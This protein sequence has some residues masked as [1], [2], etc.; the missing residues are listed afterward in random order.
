MTSLLRQSAIALLAS[1]VAVCVSVAQAATPYRVI[2]YATEWNAQQAGTLEHIDALIFAF[3][4]VNGNGVVLPGDAAERL[5][6][7]VALKQAK[8]SLQVII[9]VGGWGAG[10]F[11]EMAATAAGREAFAR[12]AAQMV[13]THGVDGI[14]MDWE[15]PGRA[16]AGIAASPDDR[17]NFTLLLEA[18]RAAL[19][20][21]AGEGRHYTLTAAVADGSAAEGIDI[22]AVEPYLDWFNLMTYDFVNS[23]TPTTGH[24]AGLH[25]SRLAPPDARSV[26]RAV[27]EYLAAGVP[28]R[29]L[30]IGAAFYGREFGEVTPE[31]DGLYQRYGSYVTEHSWPQIKSD[32]ID[33]NG[34]VRH[35]DPQAQAS[36]LWNASTRRFITYDDPQSIAAKAA[37][38]K[39]HGLGGI[40]YWEQRHDP[41]GDLVEAV[42]EGLR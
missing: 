31:H 28:P 4:K 1:L 20:A 9:A 17:A 26:D 3:A 7:M 18:L 10:G 5:A 27:R 29:K 35:Y 14:D 19:D 41:E 30:V 15:Y 23:A 24:H 12:S 2:G 6:R 40:M 11:S 37:Y 16:D 8:P 32:Y 34:F 22:A 33:R 39:A 36:W 25:A 13:Q 42:W 38:V 21:A